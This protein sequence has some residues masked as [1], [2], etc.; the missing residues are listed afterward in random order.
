MMTQKEFEEIKQDIQTNTGTDLTFTGKYKLEDLLNDFSLWKYSFE[1]K[2]EFASFGNTLN[3]AACFN[4]YCFVRLL[5]KHYFVDGNKRFSFDFLFNKIIKKYGQHLCDIDS[6]DTQILSYISVL[7]K[8]KNEEAELFVFDSL[9]QSFYNNS[10]SV[11]Q[12]KL[13]DWKNRI[14]QKLAKEGE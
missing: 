4:I 9:C 12:K 10:Q 5:Q 8:T 2:P 14:L 6:F 3:K 7:E 1:H 11:D 13:I